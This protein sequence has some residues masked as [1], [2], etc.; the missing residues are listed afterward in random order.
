MSCARK[1]SSWG[2]RAAAALLTFFY[3]QA[4]LVGADDAAAEK[5]QGFIAAL[6]SPDT[7]PQ[8]KAMACKQLARCGGP[9][10]VPALAALLSDEKLAA[11]SRIA[12]EAI[13]DAA[14]D[15]AL[16]D[17]A[18]KLQGRLLVGVINSLGMRRDAKAVEILA[19]K[20]KDAD[21][22][23]ASAAAVALGRIG[24]DDAAKLLVPALASTA[25]EVRSAVAE[26]CILCAEQSERSGDSDAAIRLF[27]AVRAADVP[28]QRVL[29]AT[30]GAILAGKNDAIPLLLQLLR[31]DDRAQFALGLRVAREL[32]GSAMTASLVAE[33]D[34][35]APERQALL[36]MALTDRSDRPE[37]AVL[38]RFAERGAKNVRIAAV[39]ALRRQGDAACVPALLTVVADADAEVSAAAVEALSEL[40]GEGVDAELVARLPRVAAAT[41][42]ALIEIVGR[43]RI[44]SA[45]PALFEA[46]DAKDAAVRRAAFKAL[47]ETIDFAALPRLIDRIARAKPEE[48]GEAAEGLRTAAGRMPDREATAAQLAASMPA[49]SAAAKCKLLESLGA[50][51]GARALEAVAAAA[52]DA[53]ADVQGAA[54]AQLGAWMTPDAAPALLEAANHAAN[55]KLKVRA[56]RGY[57]RIARQFVLPDDERLA[58][59]RAAMELA[60]RDDEKRLALDVLT[61]IPS[62]ATLDLAMSHLGDAALK[63]AAADAAVKITEKLLADQAKRL[64]EAMRKVQDAGVP[65]PLKVRAQALQE[66]A[67]AAGKAVPAK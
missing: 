14:A 34:R 65:D 30:R 6:V 26:G 64:E 67:A 50:V 54:L 55:D 33:L 49:S 12:L 23:V 56:L 45:V 57:L 62:N 13:P 51:G 47:G 38:T 53:D 63:E 35:T 52:K 9:A 3:A 36:L 59:Y 48:L 21:P 42:P 32:P 20:L 46:A 37:L 66:R 31:S 7:P 58:M 41:R 8:D 44:A 28:Q 25:P 15:A 61:R 16:R 19:E 27:H 17:A 43:R 4:T 1:V 18:G 2:I 22:E 29:E 39:Q 11:W 5:E 60:R 40:A 24:G 10:S